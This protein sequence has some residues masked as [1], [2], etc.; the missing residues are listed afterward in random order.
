LYNHINNI[1]CLFLVTVLPVFEKSIFQT[2]KYLWQFKTYEPLHDETNIVRL[3][4]A[5]IQTSL[6]I[7]VVWSGSKLFAIS[8]STCYRVCKRTARILIRLRG[9]AAG[10]DPC[11][12]Q[13]HYV[14]FVMTRLISWTKTEIIISLRIAIQFCHKI[15]INRSLYSNKYWGIINVKEV[16]RNEI[17]TSELFIAESHQDSLSDISLSLLTNICEHSMINSDSFI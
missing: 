4:Q 14:G 11:W 16:V 3:R 7:R 2:L 8:F 6:R 17:F 13:M 12:S 15:V 9:C 10:L 5:L 1:S